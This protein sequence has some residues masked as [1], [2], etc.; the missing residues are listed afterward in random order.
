MSF[1]IRTTAFADGGSIPKMFSCEGA[2]LS[3]ALGWKDA[4]AGTQSLVLIV[5]DPDAPG[6]TWTHWVIWNIPGSATTLPQG[7]P[8]TAVLDNG[9]RQGKNDFGKIGYGGP[10]PPPG[11]SHRYY[12]KLFALDTRLDL[13]AGASRSELES[14]A[15]RHVLSQ[16]KL[17]GT[18]KR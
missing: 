4:P 5:D 14:V 12:F 15:R 9:A 11:K 1:A 2:N 8:A 17:M 13:K 18:Y 16:T 3:P 6:G 7:I 10:C